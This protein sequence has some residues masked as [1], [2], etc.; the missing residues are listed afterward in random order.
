MRAEKGWRA[1]VGAVAGAVAGGIVVLIRLCCH[2]SVSFS[3]LSEGARFANCLYACALDQICA[4]KSE[5]GMKRQRPSEDSG[6][7]ARCAA[8]LKPCASGDCEFHRWKRTRLKFAPSTCAHSISEAYRLMMISAF[9]TTASA[10]AAA[11]AVDS[12]SGRKRLMRSGTLK[13]RTAVSLTMTVDDRGD[14]SRAAVGQL[15]SFLGLLQD[16]GTAPWANHFFSTNDRMLKRLTAAH[17]PL[18]VGAKAAQANRELLVSF[19]D[20]E[21]NLTDARNT[22]WITNRQQGK[23]STL[24]KFIAALALFSPC[25]GL[26]ST[27]YSTGLDRAVELIKAA[28]Q[29]INWFRTSFK[30]QSALSAVAYTRDNE[31]S[32]TLRTAAGIENEVAARPRSVDSCRGDAPRS[33]FFDEAAFMSEN[34]WSGWL[35]IGFFRIAR[36]VCFLFGFGG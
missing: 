14:A 1:A 23:T 9:S 24:G 35:R 10:A 26:L 5:P 25:G 17:L 28:K 16:L 7:S 22:V 20:S 19:C 4:R 8:G 21:T 18:I 32:F 27:I 12:G 30:G 31:R 34:F 29:Y 11:A 33:A 15:A 3:F 6:E 36:A 13:R 2:F